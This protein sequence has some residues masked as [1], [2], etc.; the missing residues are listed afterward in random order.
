MISP[1]EALHIV[2]QFMFHAGMAGGTLNTLDA[3]KLLHTLASTDKAVVV[4]RPNS[5]LTLVLDMP[6]DDD[7][8]PIRVDNGEYGQ[9]YGHFFRD[10][11]G[12]P[13]AKKIFYYEH[14]GDNRVQEVLA[15]ELLGELA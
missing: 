2:R 6:T 11:V 9:T 5:G 7:W 10:I 14:N 13:P 4:V 3:S 12:G 15:E 1:N 8:E